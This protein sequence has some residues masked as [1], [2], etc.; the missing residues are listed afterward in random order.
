[1]GPPY[2]RAPQA[3][4]TTYNPPSL[5]RTLRPWQALQQ[6]RASE[7]P[8][9]LSCPRCID[10]GIQDKSKGS[11]Q[12]SLLGLRIIG[13]KKRIGI[14]KPDTGR[15]CV[16]DVSNQMFCQM[17][18]VLLQFYATANHSVEFGRTVFNVARN[19][20]PNCRLNTQIGILLVHALMPSFDCK[21]LGDVVKRE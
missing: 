18:R 16:P 15:R 17:L 8:R 19:E 2:H 10:P 6:L 5:C 13:P 11:S 3:Q 1:M 21:R 4:H 20:L 9:W 7:A 14:P 12:C